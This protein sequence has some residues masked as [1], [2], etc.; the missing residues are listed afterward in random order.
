MTTQRSAYRQ[1]RALA[2]SGLILALGLSVL[3]GCVPVP[4]ANM[5]EVMQ[6]QDVDPAGLIADRY[7][8]EITGLS[9]TMV[10]SAVDVRY[11]VLDAG[12]ATAWLKDQAA[13]P[14]L[15]VEG[16][17]MQVSHPPSMMHMPNPQVG[18]GYHML[19]PNAGNAIKRGDRVMV[20][21]GDLRVGPL[22][23]E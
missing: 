4:A 11:R 19:L 6:H 12:Q 16:S 14:M 17:D 1:P 22:L 3:S 13:M 9:L 15:M 21:I 5:P 7:G 23:A 2:L 18:K 10:N 8:I 20:L